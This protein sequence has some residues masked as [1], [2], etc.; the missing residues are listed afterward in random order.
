[1]LLEEHKEVMRLQQ[2]IEDLQHEFCHSAPGDQSP[3]WKTKPD[4]SG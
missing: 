1:M 4:E 3:G 2:K